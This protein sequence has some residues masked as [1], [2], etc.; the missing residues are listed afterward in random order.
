[1]RRTVQHDG[2]LGIGSIAF[3]ATD[4]AMP[5]SAHD[6]TSIAAANVSP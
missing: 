2:R 4:Y 6:G 3:A 5:G 1:M